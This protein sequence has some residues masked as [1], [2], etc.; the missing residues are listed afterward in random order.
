MKWLHLLGI[1][2]YRFKG[3]SLP[4]PAYHLHSVHEWRHL[5]RVG[6]VDPATLTAAF[7]RAAILT[8]MYI[9][10]S[11]RGAPLALAPLDPSLFR[12]T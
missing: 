12:N 2:K 9:F 4:H 6:K 5:V 3:V 1:A 7:N 11:E 10:A 8:G